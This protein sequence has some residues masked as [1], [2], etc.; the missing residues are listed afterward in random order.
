MRDS[1]TRNAS[2]ADQ[3]RSFSANTLGELTVVDL[4]VTSDTSVASGAEQIGEGGQVDVLVNNAGVMNVG[5]TEAYSIDE[6]KDGSRSTPSAL[7]G[8]PRLSCL[9]CASSGRV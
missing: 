5:V 9:R 1:T 3:L 4:D 2:K 8:S 6:V 7:P